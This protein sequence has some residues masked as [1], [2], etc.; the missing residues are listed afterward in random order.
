MQ[1]ILITTC[2]ALCLAGS[3]FGQSY[4]RTIS[5]T[6]DGKKVQLHDDFKI[7]LVLEDS[8]KTTI[9]K[10]VIKNNSFINPRFEKGQRGTIIFRYKKYFMWFST[11][12]YSDQNDRF[13]FGVDYRPFNKKYSN[14]KKLRGVKYLTYLELSWCILSRRNKTPQKIPPPNTPTDRVAKCLP[15]SSPPWL[16]LVFAHISCPYPSKSPKKTS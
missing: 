13:N 6:K 7:Y 15:R 11:R 5:F 4:I 8:L 10:P 14:D 2:F 16:G 3:A 9:I 12:L 1:K